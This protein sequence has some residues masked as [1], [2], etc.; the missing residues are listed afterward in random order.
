MSRL[1]G[2]WDSA[3]AFADGLRSAL[4]FAETGR[5]EMKANRLGVDGVVLNQEQRLALE[6]MR[7]GGN[8]FLTGRAGTGKST[9]VHAYAREAK[10]VALLAPTGIAALNIGGS[11]I[12]DVNEA[13]YS[14]HIK[15]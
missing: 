10:D 14:P 8:V 7:D 13:D 11:T 15:D 2:W 1:R 5:G 12:R 3:R 9:V 6:M 4:K